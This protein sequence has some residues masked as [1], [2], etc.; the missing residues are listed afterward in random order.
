[1]EGYAATEVTHCIRPQD[2]TQRRVCV[3]LRHVKEDAVKL[4]AVRSTASP[5]PRDYKTGCTVECPQESPERGAIA[6]SD[7]DS[8]CEA[9]PMN[10][11]LAATLALLRGR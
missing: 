11:G 6:P 4:A 7:S 1:M 10:R 5:D 8:E 9:D 3:L 2:T